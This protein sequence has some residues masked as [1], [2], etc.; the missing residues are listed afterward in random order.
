M[1]KATR[2]DYVK[3]V[4]EMALAHQVQ[5]YTVPHWLGM[6]T[7]YSEFC[8]LQS[9]S[10]EEKQKLNAQLNLQVKEDFPY[11]NYPCLMRAKGQG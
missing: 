11:R 10:K 3:Q 4:N 8:R 2:E 5:S 9:L 7:P 1:A 6:P